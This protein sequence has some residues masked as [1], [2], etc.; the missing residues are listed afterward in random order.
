MRHKGALVLVVCIAPLLPPLLG[1]LH[2]EAIVDDARGQLHMAVAH[3]GRPL[4]A[5]SAVTSTSSA[6]SAWVA[7]S[8]AT[9]R[10]P[11]ALNLTFKGPALERGLA[12]TEG[13]RQIVECP[14]GQPAAA[15]EKPVQTLLADWLIGMPAAER[16]V[17]VFERIAVPNGLDP[18][19]W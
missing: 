8:F 15:I 18:R 11:N 4:N 13:E 6:C 2:N 3:R 9:K 14:I 7:I 16:R 17:V 10:A 5:A 12:W 1:Y 19:C